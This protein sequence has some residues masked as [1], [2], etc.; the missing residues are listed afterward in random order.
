MY[1]VQW[2]PMHPGVFASCDGDGFV[3]V[4]DINKDTESPVCHTNAFEN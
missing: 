3:D 4:W 1:D 2:S